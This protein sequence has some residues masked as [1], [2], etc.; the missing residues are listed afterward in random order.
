MKPLATTDNDKL[1]KV[2]SF[3]EY[4]NMNLADK[5]TM[6]CQISI[7]E[8]LIPFKGMLSFC[9]FIRS[10]RA[11][12]GIKCWVLADAADSFVS[13]FSV[14]TG[15]DATV[16]KDVPLSTRVVR[17]LVVGIENLN[18]HLYV[19]NFYTSPALF[20]WL[21]DR[22]IYAC[23]TVRKG[24]LGFLKE[25]YFGR[26]RHERATADYLSCGCLLAQSKG[27]YFPSTIFTANYSVETPAADRTVRRRSAAGA[28]DVAASPFL[29]DYT[30]T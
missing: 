30:A 16:K 17:Q 28:I 21:K 11:R 23:D 18:H 29:R 24:R 4:I 15:R 13:R 14:N 1:Y 20:R 25:L 10:K 2:R 19:D 6:G 7:D 8:S 3:V 12:F 5:Y 27:V 22:H 9:Q 26:G